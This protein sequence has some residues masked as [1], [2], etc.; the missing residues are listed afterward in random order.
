MATTD[1]T[2]ERHV[3]LI[4]PTS[5]SVQKLSRTASVVVLLNRCVH[6]VLPF[7]EW[8]G[9]MSSSVWLLGVLGRV[10]AVLS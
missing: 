8:S 10:Q 4:S 3:R 1:K 5:G 6:T 7:N 9:V 2:W